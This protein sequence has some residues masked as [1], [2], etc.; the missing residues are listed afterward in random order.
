[1]DEG[2]KVENNQI[3][4]M[5][6]VVGFWLRLITDILDVI[7]LGL[8][9]ALLAL[10][11]RGLFYSIGEDGLWIGLCITFLYTG[12]LQSNIGHGQSLAKKL[13]KIQVL[14]RD[15]SYLSLPRSFLRYTIVMLQSELDIVNK[16]YSKIDE[17]DYVNV[18][19]RTGFNIGIFSYYFRQNMR[20]TTEGKLLKGRQNVKSEN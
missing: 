17:C 20:F 6:I 5:K 8:F 14:R 13:L 11:L 16:S 2:E 4:E 1:M 12:I 7:F 18:Q 9:G 15:G 19:A 3:K 10:P